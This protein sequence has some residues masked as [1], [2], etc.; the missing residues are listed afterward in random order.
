M[1]NVSVVD[2]DSVSAVLERGR[3]IPNFLITLGSGTPSVAITAVQPV[4][5]EVE[6]GGPAELAGMR[7]GDRVIMANGQDMAG[8]DI[9]AFLDMISAYSEG[10]AP[11]QLT[12]LR[13]DGQAECSLEPFWDAELNRY[14]I[15]IAVSAAAAKL[16]AG[17]AMSAG[18]LMASSF[19]GCGVGLL[20][21]PDGTAQ[22]DDFADA[23]LAELGKVSFGGVC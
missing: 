5:A 23:Q 17:H 13:E 14:R 7:A 19:T 22:V 10:D 2:Q 1:P 3:G 9:Q 11:I 21:P 12:V 15:G 16:Y 6:P 18:A 8:A 4:I 20:V